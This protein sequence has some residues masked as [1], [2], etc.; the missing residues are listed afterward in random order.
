MPVHVAAAIGGSF[1]E[2]HAATL[3]DAA[4]AKAQKEVGQCVI[5]P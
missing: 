1:P 5:T 3:E 2:Q 4:R